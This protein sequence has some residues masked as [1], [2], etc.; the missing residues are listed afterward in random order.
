MMLIMIQEL[1]SRHDF[2]VFVIIIRMIA[3]EITEFSVVPKCMNTSFRFN[4]KILKLKKK[5]FKLAAK[6]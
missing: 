4:V 6:F 2:P 3:E 5:K 1:K